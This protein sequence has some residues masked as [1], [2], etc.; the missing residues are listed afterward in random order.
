MPVMS[1]SAMNTTPISALAPATRSNPSECFLWNTYNAEHTAVTVN[2]RY[3][4]H[5]V[6]TCTYMMRT[7]S[8]W[9]R[10][11]GENSKPKA[12]VQP[13]ITSVATPSTRVAWVPVPAER[14]A[15]GS[16][17]SGGLTMKFT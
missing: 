10:S 12:A 8:P 15:V 9:L 1:V 17:A 13:I 16:G 11:A 4:V 5:T 14:E 2:A 3:A 7:E 6:G